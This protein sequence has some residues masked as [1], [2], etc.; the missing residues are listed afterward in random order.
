MS[1]DAIKSEDASV[2]H[3]HNVE[4]SERELSCIGHIVA[5]WG[6][7]EFE[8]FLQT[9]Q[10]FGEQ[11][12]VLPK[13][14]NNMQFSEVIE[15][16]K[17][18]V[19]DQA[20]GDKKKNLEDQYALIRHYHEYRNALVH[21]MWDWDRSSPARIKTTRVRKREVISTHFTSE[22]LEE[23][24]LE[25]AKINFNIRNPNGLQDLARMINTGGY[26]SRAAASILSG[27]TLTADGAV[28]PPS[29]DRS[30]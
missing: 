6:A 7:L 12:Q 24:S 22:D 9:L 10:T 14:M 20:H 15:K 28:E 11:A 16:W 26:I 13:V 19:V 5:Q 4:L 2:D 23:F 18:R 27:Q 17:E 1:D 8:I 21:G 29:Q 30:A 25:I 3:A